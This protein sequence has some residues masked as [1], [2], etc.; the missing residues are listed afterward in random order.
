MGIEKFEAEYLSRDIMKN[1]GMLQVIKRGTGKIVAA[2]NDGVLLFDEIS[3]A[4]MLSA[5]DT[6][7]VR[8]W[9]QNL[10]NP[11]V[12]FL[13]DGT[14]SSFLK[15]LYN[16]KHSLECEQLVYIADHPIVYEKR[17]EIKEPLNEE[18]SV[19]RKHYHRLTDSELE[20]VRSLH[21][22]MSGMT[23]WTYCWLYRLPSRG[24]YGVIG[25]FAGISAYGLGTE[26]ES[27]M[28][29]KCLERG[30]VPFGHVITETWNP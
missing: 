23:N 22:C 20:K 2:G 12:F 3:E 17:L 28:I 29:N 15:K 8:N 24:E 25:D 16:L 4:Y 9:L 21:N 26:L 6:A 30:F 13:T 27:F 1:C 18:M 5:K 10:P 19:V 14:F 11:E 7:E